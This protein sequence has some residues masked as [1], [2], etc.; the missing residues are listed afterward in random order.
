[1][2]FV[3]LYAELFVIGKYRSEMKK[4]IGYARYTA[5][6]TLICNTFVIAF[7]IIALLYFMWKYK[8]LC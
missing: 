1:M 8:L 4:A 5:K 3:Y 7:F 2:L 6:R